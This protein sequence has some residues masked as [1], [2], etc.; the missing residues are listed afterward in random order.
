MSKHPLEVNTDIGYIGLLYYVLPIDKTCP[1][2]SPSQCHTT[3]LLLLRLGPCYEF[4]TAVFTT[5]NGMFP[6]DSL[7]TSLDASFH[8]R[9]EGKGSCSIP[10]LNSCEDKDKFTT[11]DKIDPCVGYIHASSGG[12]YLS[13]FKYAAQGD[14]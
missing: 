5:A 4:I 6:P 7:R 12:A 3:L 1:I 11:H 10:L 2:H 8:S 9:L 13:S 14:K